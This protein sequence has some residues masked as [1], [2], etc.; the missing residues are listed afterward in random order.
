MNNIKS[1]D[2]VMVV[3]PL[4]CCGKTGGIGK[5]F[6]V[7]SVGYYTTRCQ[8]CGAVDTASARAAISERGSAY[9]LTRLKRIDPPE[10]QKTRT[11]TRDMETT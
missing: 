8:T 7:H 3:R 2:L 1:G 6:R 10:E 11:A 5:V 4:E 9:L